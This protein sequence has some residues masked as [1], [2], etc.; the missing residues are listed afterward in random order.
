MNPFFSIVIP[1][2][3]GGK[4]IEECLSSI[5]K[6][7]YCN[8]EVIVIND[9]S[10]DNSV[11]I[12]Q[13]IS[14]YNDRIKLFSKDNG[15]VASARNMGI[16][17]SNGRYIIFLD[18]D[19]LMVPECL[20]KIS[21]VLS[22]KAMD[23]TICTSYIEMDNKNDKL[24][25]LFTDEAI[26]KEKTNSEIKKLCQNL[27]S[28]CIAVY[29]R[30]FLLNNDLYVREGVTCGEDTE[31]FFNALVLSKT[32]QLADVALFAYR[33]NPNSVSNDLSYKNVMD[34][35]DVCSKK[36]NLLIESP[37]SELDNEK[38]LDFFTTKYIHFAVKI[39]SFNREEKRRAFDIVNRDKDILG[40][41]Y[42]KTNKIFFRMINLIG[43]KTTIYIY[44]YALKC[45]NRMKNG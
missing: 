44:Y 41:A 16:M 24:N 29:R 6:Q 39:A 8:Y 1:V 14:K 26:R 12:V 3:N 27:S 10:T 18:A 7:K 11:N 42:N 2:Y 13:K 25:R 31:F 37:F 38:A 36:I 15:G 20:E 32:L 33:F 28:M 4:Y 45:R 17:K 40:Y 23:L 43:V 34:V 5:V 19:D 21:Q 30:Q 9:G 35:M 22:N